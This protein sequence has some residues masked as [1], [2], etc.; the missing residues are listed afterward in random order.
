MP[1]KVAR[2]V[3][4]LNGSLGL[5]QMSSLGPQRGVKVGMLRVIQL[6][7]AYGS[8]PLSKTAPSIFS[9]R[10]ISVV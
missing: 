2:L 1:E 5:K 3:R 10:A 7:N 4:L 9:M 8:R 6:Q